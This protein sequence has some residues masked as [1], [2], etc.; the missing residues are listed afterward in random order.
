MGPIR[1][2]SGNLVTRVIEKAEVLTDLFAL[3]VTCKHSTLTAEVAD[4]QR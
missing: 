4:Q 2:E 1:K 3:I